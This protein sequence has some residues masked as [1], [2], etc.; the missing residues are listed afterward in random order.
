MRAAKRS[1]LQTSLQSHNKEIII[2][3]LPIVRAELAAILSSKGKVPMATRKPTLKVLSLDKEL[4]E[5]IKK[6]FLETNI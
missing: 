5:N 4:E 1:S 3:S 2:D 6:R